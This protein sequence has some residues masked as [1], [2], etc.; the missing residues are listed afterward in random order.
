MMKKA[1]HGV[2][3]SGRTRE[4]RYIVAAVIIPHPSERIKY[5]WHNKLYLWLFF[6]FSF[7]TVL[8]GRNIRY[9]AQANVA[10]INFEKRRAR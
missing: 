6:L 5:L 3:F 7:E 2:S 9:K 10:G 1:I 8:L 4:A